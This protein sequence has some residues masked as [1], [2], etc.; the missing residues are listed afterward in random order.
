MAGELAFSAGE[1]AAMQATQEA[2]MMD[3]CVIQVFTAGARNA[4]GIKAVSYVDGSAIACGF[5]IKTVADQLEATKVKTTKP[6]LRLPLATVVT[7]KDRIKLTH[8]Y[9]V[10]ITA[11]IY[12]IVGEPKRGPS[13]LV[14]ELERV[15]DGT[16]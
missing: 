4:A 12:Q 15:T 16:T 9:G 10:A 6:E 1:L 5:H 13:G 7:G 11:E 3:T 8:R 2:H 14:L